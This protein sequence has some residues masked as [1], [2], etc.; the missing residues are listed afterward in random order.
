MINFYGAELLAPHVTPKLEDHPLSAVHDYLF[1]IFA[2]T[3][4]IWGPFRHHQPEDV[5]Y[6]SDRDPL[7]TVLVFTAQPKLPQHAQVCR[8]V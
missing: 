8:I 4:H 7:S 5:P 2:A 6:H 3:L 1:H